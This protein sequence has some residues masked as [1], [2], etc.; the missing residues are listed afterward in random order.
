LRSGAVLGFELED[1]LCGIAALEVIAA[2]L[3][4][5]PEGVDASCQK[6]RSSVGSRSIYLQ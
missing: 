1:E 6:L 5:N 2:L 3:L 4:G